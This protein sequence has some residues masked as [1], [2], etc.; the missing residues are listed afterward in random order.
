[1]KFESKRNLQKEKGKQK[2]CFVS[3]KT[4]F[5]FCYF[6]ITPFPLLFKDVFKILK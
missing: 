5:L 2:K 3:W 4:Y 1:M 6:F